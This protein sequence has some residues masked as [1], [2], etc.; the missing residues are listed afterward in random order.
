[1]KLNRSAILSSLRALVVGSV[2]VAAP[3]WADRAESD[4][5]L[6]E[7]RK[8]L[9]KGDY[10]SAIIQLKNAVRADGN[11]LEARRALGT[12]QLAVGDLLS[13][14]KEL[15]IY[16]EKAPEDSAAI[17]P[18]GEALLQLRRY[19]DVIARVQPKGRAKEI[20]AH[21]L[22]LRGHALAATGRS[23][24][25]TQAFDQSLQLQPTVRAHLGYA[26]LLRR[27]QGLAPA[28]AEVDKALAID[29]KSPEAALAKAEIRRDAG[30]FDG[31]LALANQALTS[32][33]LEVPAKLLR[34]ALFIRQGKD[35]SAS[36][37]VKSVL[38]KIKDQPLATYY[39]ALLAARANDLDGA[40]QALQSLSPEFVD[41][42][43]PA[44]FLSGMTAYSKG[45]LDVAEGRLRSYVNKLPS[46]VPARKVLGAIYLRKGDPGKALAVL[47]PGLKDAPNDARL[48]TLLGTASERLG[49]SSE[50]VAYFERA[51]EQS[52]DDQALQTQLALG[53]LRTGQT[54]EAIQALEGVVD[55]DPTAT[56]ATSALLAAHI[57]GGAFDK[58]MAEVA[59]LRK[60]TPDA[61]LPDYYEG[62]ILVAQRDLAAGRKAFEAALKKDPKFH[63]ARFAL[64]RVDVAE[65]KRDQA[66]SQIAKVLEAEPGNQRAVVEMAELQATDGKLDAAIATLDKARRADPNAVNV[67]LRLVDAYLAKKEGE[68]AL[69]VARETATLTGG[70]PQ[71]LDAL[72]RAQSAVG[73]KASA[74][75]T[76]R[77]LVAQ[78]PQSG[79]ALQ[80]LAG[81]LLLNNDVAGAKQAL[82]Q[83]ARVDPTFAPAQ[84]D[85]VRLAARDGAEAAIAA[86]KELKENSPS[87]AVAPVLLGE[88]Y[89]QAKKFGDAVAVFRQIR[90]EKPSSGVLVREAEALSADRKAA[91]ARGLLEGWLKDKPEDHAVRLALAGQY[92]QVNDEPSA[93]KQYEAVLA[94]APNNVL[95][96][97][98]LAWSLRE[99]DG[100]RALTL[101]ARAAELAPNAAEVLDTYGWLLVLRNEHGKAIEPLQKAASVPNAPAAVRYHLASALAGAGRND[102]ARKTLDELL[103]AN[104]PFDER[105]DA[106]ALR[107]KLAN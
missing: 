53:K 28:E 36:E 75:G 55:K 104:A 43:A 93:I 30:D 47:E 9:E 3:A 19:D 106:E 41:N 94:A 26:A 18:Y 96:L 15:G 81:A 70:N 42:Y 29:P 69:V 50:A 107:R 67:R 46:S 45:Q 86:A 52:P 91:E 4:K 84:Q 10:R 101:A 99:R 80:R 68:R 83:A 33:R 62:A 74:V 22:A 27:S 102:E 103:A 76:Y 77:Q 79:A 44:L 71:S 88:S 66:M 63:A 61:P 2:L 34:I 78:L 20:E 32:P 58:A 56:R 7:A 38:A 87:S 40:Q 12:A 97:N 1:M 85:Y 92:L 82:L 37:D 21:V 6:G 23:E 16:V 51:T 31:A 90:T 57:R 49:K 8:Q 95:A 59:D 17:V 60:R 11:N 65:G 5:Y 100:A 39:K 24:Q 25:A 105:A 98:N 35:A 14:E 48:L 73:D 13:A 64:A 72:G 89:M 54:E